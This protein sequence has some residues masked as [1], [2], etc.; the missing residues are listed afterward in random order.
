M[1]TLGS[2]IS[3]PVHRRVVQLLRA[4]EDARIPGVVNLHPAYCSVLIRF[5]SLSTS[6]QSLEA[7]VRALI[8]LVATSEPPTPRVVEIPVRYGGEFGPDLEEVA[9][10]MDQTMALCESIFG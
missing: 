6:H 10:V 1:V 4:L 5:D 9:D 8:E 2:E 3:L 7:R